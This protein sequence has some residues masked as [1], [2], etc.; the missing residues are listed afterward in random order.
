MK[1]LDVRCL[2]AHLGSRVRRNIFSSVLRIFLLHHSSLN[3]EPPAFHRRDITEL[4][5]LLFGRLRNMNPFQTPPAPHGDKE[6]TLEGL[7]AARRTSRQVAAGRRDSAEGGSPVGSPV[8]M[9]WF[10]PMAVALHSVE[11]L[12]PAVQLAALDGTLGPS[13]SSGHPGETLPLG[14]L[15]LPPGFLSGSPPAHR[16]VSSWPSE[17][18]PFSGS[19]NDGQGLRFQAVIKD[20]Y[21]EGKPCESRAC[22]NC[23]YRY[24]P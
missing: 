18:H 17:S 20:F 19:G 12:E 10:S 1:K 21:S 23:V 11:L 8:P 5:L 3:R 7:P 16:Q 6:L 14:A 22:V 24:V 2:L 9:A 13:G 15:R 4:G